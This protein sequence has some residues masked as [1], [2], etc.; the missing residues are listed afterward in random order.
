MSLLVFLTESITSPSDRYD[1]ILAVTDRFLHMNL[2]AMEK[3]HISKLLSSADGPAD[4]LTWTLSMIHGLQLSSD[5]TGRA[6][7]S[8]QRWNSGSSVHGEPIVCSADTTVELPG[9]VMQKIVRLRMFRL[10]GLGLCIGVRTPE[11][12]S[13]RCGSRECIGSVDGL[14]NSDRK[15][16]HSNCY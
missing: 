8:E 1:T 10:M 12:C 13:R 4:T 14:G 7:A 9:W 2:T 3:A 16:S 5:D 6:K 15:G 11:T